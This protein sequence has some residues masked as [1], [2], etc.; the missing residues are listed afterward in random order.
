MGRVIPNDR[1]PVTP[2]VK[3]VALDDPV[4]EERRLRKLEQH[5]RYYEK[6]REHILEKNAEWKAKARENGWSRSDNNHYLGYKYGITLDEYEEMLAG[7]NGVCASCGTPPSGRKLS[8]DHD[9]ETGVIRGLLCQPCNT[10]LGLLKE[11]PDRIASLL[12]YAFSHQDVLLAH[13]ED[14]R[15]GT[16]YTK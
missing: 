16:S 9:H 4:L 1:Q 2:G 15:Y 13:K 10:A 12:A 6:N 14:V 3:P 5:R 11:S 8:V 7:Q